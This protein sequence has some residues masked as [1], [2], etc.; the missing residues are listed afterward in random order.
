MTSQFGETSWIFQP[1]TQ[2]VDHHFP[3][4]PCC[5]GAAWADERE[6][7]PHWTGEESRSKNRKG[8]VVPVGR[9]LSLVIQ[10][11]GGPESR[12]T[13]L[14]SF[15]FLVLYVLNMTCGIIWDIWDMWYMFVWTQA[16]CLPGW[17]HWLHG[18]SSVQL[19][20][21]GGFF[22]TCWKMPIVVGHIIHSLVCHRW[23]S[24]SGWF[25]CM[26]RWKKCSGHLGYDFIPTVLDREIVDYWVPVAASIDGY[27]I[28]SDSTSE[29]AKTYHGSSR[30]RCIILQYSIVFLYSIPIATVGVPV[31]FCVILYVKLRPQQLQCS[32]WP[33]W[34]PM[35]MKHL[36]CAEPWF[37][38]CQGAVLNQLDL[39]FFQT[40]GAHRFGSCWL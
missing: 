29:F 24:G 8:H 19:S 12:W 25:G 34:R 37:V 22:K 9:F 36:P 21:S 5:W 2:V 23:F 11:G 35:M 4:F 14:W 40:S 28:F 7:Q 31:I 3:N 13:D 27:I 33:R 18:K 30:L 15:K 32:D 10:G 20:T 16:D 1:Q 26:F 39:F 38:A 6:V 17:G